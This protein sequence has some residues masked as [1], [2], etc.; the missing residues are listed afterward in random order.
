MNNRYK[1]SAPFQ[2]DSKYQLNYNEKK[3]DYLKSEMFEQWPLLRSKNGKDKERAFN[4]YLMQNM[5][6]INVR[7]LEKEFLRLS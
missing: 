6:S 2:K 3:L 1:I 7:L 4:K 5:Q